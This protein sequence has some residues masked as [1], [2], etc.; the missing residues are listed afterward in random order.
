MIAI[1]N[2]VSAFLIIIII[3]ILLLVLLFRAHISCSVMIQCYTCTF[4]AF[5]VS[6]ILQH[7]L[8]GYIEA[9]ADDNVL[10]MHDILPRE[11]LLRKSITH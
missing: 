1:V 9:V 8:Y 6:Y 10:L 2:Y 3:T 5:I 4:L 7:A 11:T